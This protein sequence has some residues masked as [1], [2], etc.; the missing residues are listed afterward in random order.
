MASNLSV[1]SF[2]F[3]PDSVVR[4]SQVNLTVTVTGAIGVLTLAYLGLPLGCLS[5][6]SSE[7]AC[8]PTQVGSFAA[9]V[10]VTDAG[11]NVATSNASLTVLPGNG[12]APKITGFSITPSQVQVKHS[13]FVV[14]DA[15]SESSTPDALLAFSY[16]GLPP[17][18]ASFNQ[19]N[20]TCSPSQSGTFKVEVEVTDGFGAFSYASA[21]LTVESGSPVAGPSGGIPPVV[22]TAG[23]GGIGLGVAILILVRGRMPPDPPSSEG[24]S[25]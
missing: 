3:H 13:S 17:G 21:N 6:N 16:F 1:V 14:V 18:C 8:D 20:L 9:E 24:R 11:G 2:E 5:E 19:T 7:F 4:G 25:Q 12:G 10:Q 15:V 23:I 22:Y